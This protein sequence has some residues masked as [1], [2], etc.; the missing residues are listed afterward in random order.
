MFYNPFTPSGFAKGIARAQLKSLQA[1]QRR[2]PS[3]KKEELYCAAL[4]TRFGSM[5]LVP[6]ILVRDAKETVLDNSPAAEALG[7][8][9]NFQGE[10]YS[11]RGPTAP[12]ALTPA[13]SRRE[14]EKHGPDALAATQWPPP[15]RGRAP[16]HVRQTVDRARYNAPDPARHRS[17]L[18]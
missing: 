3:M 13:L 15:P 1:A 16:H 2:N 4:R 17:A 5:S 7:L 9:F 6:A 11:R 8:G 10:D 12:T 14:R 18:G